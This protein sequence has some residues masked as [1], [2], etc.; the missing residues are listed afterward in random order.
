MDNI[1]YVKIV[2]SGYDSNTVAVVA[3]ERHI[4]Y[5]PYIDILSRDSV[6]FRETNCLHMYYVE[7]QDRTYS[8]IL[9][10]IRRVLK[11]L[12]NLS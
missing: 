2:E 4:R 9:Q 3:R 8:V 5:L 12:L 1:R 6:I 7:R 10:K 11:W